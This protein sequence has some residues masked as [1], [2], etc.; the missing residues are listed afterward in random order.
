MGASPFLISEDLHPLDAE[1]A[2]FVTGEENF[3]TGR[4]LFCP[5]FV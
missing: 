5:V 2:H 3:F 1:I 4:E